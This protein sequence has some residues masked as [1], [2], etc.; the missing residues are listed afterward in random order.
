MSSFYDI[1]NT[2]KSYIQDHQPLPTTNDD[3]NTDADVRINLRFVSIETQLTTLTENCSEADSSSLAACSQLSTFRA[4]TDHIETQISS[5]QQLLKVTTQQ[6]EQNTNELN[7]LKKIVEQSCL[8]ELQNITDRIDQLEHNTLLQF[9]N[10]ET[11]LQQLETTEQQHK[12]DLVRVFDRM[13]EM[14]EEFS[15]KLEEKMQK[16]IRKDGKKPPRT[17]PRLPKFLSLASCGGKGLTREERKRKKEQEKEDL[18]K[19]EKQE[20]KQKL[21]QWKE[22]KEEERDEEREKE[23]AKGDEETKLRSDMEQSLV[24]R[25]ASLVCKVPVPILLRRNGNDVLRSRMAG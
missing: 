23:I 20:E 21:I 10:L 13:D 15:R 5:H 3:D 9:T 2:K 22:Q 17:K 18:E 8:P 7:Q 25:N 14:E 19:E 6:R 12:K 11:R 4:R 24:R 16:Y 1:P